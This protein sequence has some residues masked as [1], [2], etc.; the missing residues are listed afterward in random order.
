VD[1][2]RLPVFFGSGFLEPQFYY[3][4]PILF[5]L[6]IS[7]SFTGKKV[8]KRVAQPTF[9]RIVLAA[10]G[11]VSLIFVYDGVTQLI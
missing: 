2:T 4:L 3:Y 1:I 6:A 5:L 8:V 7:G 9:R 11:L 10:I